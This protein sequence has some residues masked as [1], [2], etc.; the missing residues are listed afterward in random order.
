MMK[1]HI[2]FDDAGNVGAISH[3]RTGKNGEAVLGGFTPHEGQHMATVEVPS[4]LGHLKP[5][6]LH[7]AVRVEHVGGVPRLIAK[8][9]SGSKSVSA[10]THKKKR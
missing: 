5:R 7:D 4:E 2:L 6:D 3:P 10:K 9:G 1:V 8:D